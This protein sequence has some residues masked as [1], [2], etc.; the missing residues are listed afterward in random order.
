[1]CGSK[2]SLLRDVLLDSAFYLSKR[3]PQC[4]TGHMSAKS[5]IWPF[6]CRHADHRQ[7]Q[8]HPATSLR[9][10]SLNILLFLCGPEQTLLPTCQPANLPTHTFHQEREFFPGHTLSNQ[11]QLH[12]ISARHQQETPQRNQASL[13]TAAAPVPTV[14]HTTR[15]RTR[16]VQQPG[17]L[18]ANRG[19]KRDDA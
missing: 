9:L 3:S 15:H 19:Q 4:R 2:P 13:N 1:M 6:P 5:R 11:T 18:F 16:Y 8:E 17:G 12:N 10:L 7:P 14:T